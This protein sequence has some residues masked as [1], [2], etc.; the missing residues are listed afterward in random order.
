LHRSRSST[1]IFGIPHLIHPAVKRTTGQ[2]KS[3]AQ[4]T[5]MP[6]NSLGR[7][8]VSKAVMRS[9]S[10]I[11]GLGGIVFI[12]KG[13]LLWIHRVRWQT[14][15]PF[16]DLQRAQSNRKSACKSC[17]WAG[18]PPDGSRYRSDSGRVLLPPLPVIG[19]VETPTLVTDLL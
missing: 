9:S 8:H 13:G 11:S 17:M 18:D 2:P 7:Y 5:F 10:A 4:K 16:P 3:T 19:A 12:S 1:L 14:C 15:S 6:K